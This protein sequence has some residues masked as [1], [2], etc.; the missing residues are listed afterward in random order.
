MVS[1]ISAG[2]TVD[3]FHREDIALGAVTVTAVVLS[4]TLVRWFF[5]PLLG[6]ASFFGLTI[7]LLAILVGRRARW[8]VAVGALASATAFGSF[9]TG[10]ALALAG[11]TATTVCARVWTNPE[12]HSP[13]W[14]G[15]ALGVALLTVVSVAAT[16]GLLADILEIGSFNIVFAQS[17]QLLLVPTVLGIPFVWA[18][19]GRFP[20]ARR[21][22]SQPTHGLVAAIVVLWGVVGYMVSFLLEAF[23]LVP[24]FVA[25][26]ELGGTV[27]AIVRTL[28]LG[29][30]ATVLVGITA[31][32]A[33][34]VVMKRE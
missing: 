5:T 9:D 23:G 4:E 19:T 27:A 15:H 26:Q 18:V 30:A 8:G 17:L 16:R 13:R 25:G 29:D 32:T 28:S 20:G 12:R 14:L 24:H 31:I 10:V 21:P 6:E 33:L 34:A 3:L 2:E 22:P 11:F 1:D 7:L